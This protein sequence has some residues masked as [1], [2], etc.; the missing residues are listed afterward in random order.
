MTKK[1]L[2]TNNEEQ[3]QDNYNHYLQTYTNYPLV[4]ESDKLCADHPSYIT[5]IYGNTT[6]DE[7]NLTDI[8]SVGVLQE[9][10]TYKV[11]ID[12]AGKN[13]FDINSVQM[14]GIFASCG[15]IDTADNSI[16]FTYEKVRDYGCETNFQFENG[17][18]YKISLD[19][20]YNNTNNMARL[21]AINVPGKHA[22]AYSDYIRLDVKAN[23]ISRKFSVSKTIPEDGKT[24]VLYLN[25]NNFAS[26]VTGS[27]VFKNIV[28]EEVNDVTDTK[29]ATAYVPYF[30]PQTKSIY[31]PQ[32][33]RAIGDYSDRLYWDNS[34]SKYCIEQKVDIPTGYS[35]VLDDTLVLSTPQIIETTI[36]EKISIDTYN[37]YMQITTDELEVAPTN[38]SGEFANKEAIK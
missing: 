20:E 24:Y 23:E 37:S 27:T 15:V 4:V 13:L 21:L 34:M 33:L 5:E 25:G 30:V 8:R 14:V 28:I 38:M 6:Q 7:A 35:Q 36:M 12:V 19:L 3:S 1:L 17:K 32:P 16:T 2:I 29:A 31:L 9:D 11:D 18:S 10:G 22:S 26:G